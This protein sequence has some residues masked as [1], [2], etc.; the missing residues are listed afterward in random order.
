[1]ITFTDTLGKD[2]SRRCTKLSDAEKTILFD[3]KLNSTLTLE[4]ANRYL[5][6]LEYQ[7]FEKFLEIKSD[8]S[9]TTGYFSLGLECR[10]VLDLK[11]EQVD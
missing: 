3:R 8:Y 9:K 4:E 6:L 11:V 2:Y 1:M 5:E 10:L 7:E